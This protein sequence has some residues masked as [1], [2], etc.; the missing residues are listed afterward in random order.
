MKFKI[1]ENLPLAVKKLLVDRGHD[2]HSVYDE[3]IQGGPDEK[4]IELCRVEKRHLLTLDL[5]FSDIVTYPP[6]QYRGI[7]V[8][9]LTQ[10]DSASVTA[11]VAEVLKD[12]ESLDLVGH[13][14]IVDNHKIRYR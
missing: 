4:L 13:I 2:C 6:E 10:Q 9:R 1:D 14:T 11:R 5:D 7:V 8:L 3:N 12:L